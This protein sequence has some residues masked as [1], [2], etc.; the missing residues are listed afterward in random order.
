MPGKQGR[1]AR[2]VLL[3]CNGI[4]SDNTYALDLIN[5][6]AEKR[7]EVSL[8]VGDNL[9][10]TVPEDSTLPWTPI[11]IDASALQTVKAAD[12]LHCFAVREKT[13]DTIEA[14]ARVRGCAV[15][16]FLFR[17]GELPFE[18]ARRFSTLSL[19]V[20][21][22]AYDVIP[23]KAKAFMQH[24]HLRVATGAHTQR[25]LAA[26]FPEQA[27]VPVIYPRSF[28]VA[29]TRDADRFALRRSIGIPDDRV[30]FMVDINDY[31]ELKGLD[32]VLQAYARLLRHPGAAGRVT[33]LINGNP[34]NLM[35]NNVLGVFQ[36]SSDDVRVYA[37][38]YAEGNKPV[39]AHIER[40]VSACDVF[41]HA[42]CGSDFDATAHLAYEI[43]KMVVINDIMN[44]AT[45]YPRALR[46]EKSQRFFDGMANSI[47]YFPSQSELFGIMKSAVAYTIKHR[48]QP[49]KM[50]PEAEEFRAEQTSQF[51]ARWEMLLSGVLL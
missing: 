1:N 24:T 16:V 14:L 12:L 17:N 5:W 20:S 28:G 47:L 32:V 25:L 51:G 18:A 33:L 22:M 21:N 9:G 36:F 2:S 50:R 26:A 27:I 31:I 48:G 46:L 34:N 11:N 4:M 37:A 35:L 8:V 40:L 38:C 3:V 41:V 30:V 7:V 39:H 49:L 23:T 42:A 43:G 45:Y 19:F 6:L 15:I 13:Q 10:V 44:E 29:G